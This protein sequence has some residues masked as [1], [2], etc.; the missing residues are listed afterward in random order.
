M[1]PPCPATPAPTAH[2]SRSVRSFSDSIAP[3][4][5]S[6]RRNGGVP[7]AV[8][9]WIVAPLPTMLRLSPV[10]TTG[11]PFAPLTVFWTAASVRRRRGGGQGDGV[12]A[13]NQVGLID[14]RHQL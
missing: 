3:G 10:N 8:L 6:N 13:T 5:T 11:R 14:R 2:P 12:R 9:R 7:A 1:A 4:A